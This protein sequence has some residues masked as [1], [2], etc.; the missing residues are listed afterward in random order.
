MKVKKGD[1]LSELLRD[2]F[3]LK[4]V[5]LIECPIDY[6]VNYEMF[7]KELANIVCEL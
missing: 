5:V 4:T 2:A 3:S 6:S 1:N 7:S